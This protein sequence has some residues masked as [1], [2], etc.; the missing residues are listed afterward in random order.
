MLVIIAG[1]WQNHSSK[2]T[3]IYLPDDAQTA[4]GTKLTSVSS[5]T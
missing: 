3:P 5:K 1:K 2:E 4:D